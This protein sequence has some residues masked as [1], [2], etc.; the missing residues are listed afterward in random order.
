M[1]LFIWAMKKLQQEGLMKKAKRILR[2]IFVVAKFAYGKTKNWNSSK[3]SKKTINYEILEEDLGDASP[4]YFSS[5]T[6]KKSK[7]P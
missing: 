3:N 5:E 4:K 2:G 6:T 1:E 7:V